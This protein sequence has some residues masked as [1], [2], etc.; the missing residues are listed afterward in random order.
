MENGQ[1]QKTLLTEMVE[2]LT[3][4]VAKLTKLIKDRPEP[5]PPP[6]LQPFLQRV[7]DA[8]KGLRGQI[9]K[10]VEAKPQS[11]TLA[12]ESTQVLDEL[13]AIRQDIRRSPANRITKA[14]QYGTGLLIVSLLT[15]GILAYYATKWKNERDAFEVSD[16]KWR[17]VRQESE[18]YALQIDNAF[19]SDSISERYRKRI[20]E[21]E[22]ADATREA[23]RRAA[24]QAKAMNAQADKL[25]GKSDLKSRNR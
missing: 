19:S 12:V 8:I 20:V 15:T 18:A 7:A 23:A 5:A 21:M 25:E 2:G 13:R 24:E 3:D 1:Q 22:Q 4:D 11:Q 17:V 9:E 10:L 14:V 6:D 16:W